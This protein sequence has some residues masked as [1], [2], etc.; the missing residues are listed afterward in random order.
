MFEASP[1]YILKSRQARATRR[2]PV[3]KQ[4]QRWHV[5]AIPA[6]ARRR[7]EHV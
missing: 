6:L 2:D 5:R 4:I 7:Q 3:S 1:D